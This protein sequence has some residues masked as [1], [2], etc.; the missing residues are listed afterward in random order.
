MEKQSNM[1]YKIPCSCGYVYI[2]E[3]IKEEAG[4]YRIVRNIII[5]RIHT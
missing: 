5:I 3:T 1:V 2:G 4:D